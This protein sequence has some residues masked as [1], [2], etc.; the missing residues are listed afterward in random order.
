MGRFYQTAKPEFVDDFIYQ[1][2]W[3][4]MKEAL[5]QE[6]SDYDVALAKAD[7][8]KNIDINYIE[9]PIEKEKVRQ[10]QEYYA[11]KADELTNSL[12]NSGNDWRKMMP[13]INNLKKELEADYKTGDINNIQKSAAAYK[14]MDEHLKT[15]K[16]PARREAAKK[17]YLDE[18]RKAPNRSLDQI[19]SYEDIYD[20]QDP[21]GE[22]LN[23][24]KL[25]KPDIWAK[26]TASTNG[27]YIDTKSMS[28][29][30]LKDLDKAYG[31][32]LDAKGY[33][34]YLQQ[35]QKLG[36]GTYYD[37]N[38]QRL[39]FSDPKSSAFKQM[40]YVKNFEYTQQKADADKKADP[41][42]LEA[43]QQ[44][45]RLSAMQYQASL[46]KAAKAQDLPI[47]FTKDTSF[48]YSRT[49]EGR[50]VVKQYNDALGQIAKNVGAKD[51]KDY[52][53]YIDIIRKNP[54]KYPEQFKQVTYYDN[55]LNSNQRAGTDYFKNLGFSQKQIDIVDKKFQQ[56]GVDKIL[57]HRQGYVDFGNINGKQYSGVGIN[58]GKKVS[59]NQ[60]KG[61]SI[62]MIPGYK[63]AKIENIEIVEGTAAFMPAA[64]TDGKSGVTTTVLI[65]PDVGEP[66]Y[67]EFYI[68][69]DPLNI[70]F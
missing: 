59:I 26:A 48:Y 54:Q 3:E 15:I 40:Q 57:A 27:K 14:A 6:Q 31:E 55:I 24:L 60:L 61:R 56:K 62:D 16:D 70:G 17:Y 13:Q 33:D 36:F 30:Q 37:E 58:E 39:A 53:K 65:T 7:L 22:F 68:G 12:Y 35:E 67:S 69:G 23:E 41:Y 20:K 51:P 64:D 28:T 10:K 5:G 47:S 34:P 45:N 19:F 32:F 2:P 18:W 63:G 50:A 46:D 11:S 38:G 25:S 1:P 29:E 43:V 52:D 4:L 21:T 8:F 49:K 66:F 44:A 9:D 42:G